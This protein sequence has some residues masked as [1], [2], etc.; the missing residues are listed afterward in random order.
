MTLSGAGD[1]YTKNSP[2][3]L[4]EEKEGEGEGER[5]IEKVVGLSLNR[6]RRYNSQAVKEAKV[7]RGE[8]NE[9]DVEEG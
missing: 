7:E 6:I 8:V 9:Q 2:S 5:K 1:D 4:E 3:D